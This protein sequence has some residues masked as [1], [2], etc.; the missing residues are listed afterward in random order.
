MRSV[1]AAAA[2]TAAG[3][4]ALCAAGCFAAQQQ[5]GHPAT[6]P[7]AELELEQQ[8]EPEE[9]PERW[10]QELQS[11]DFSFGE[12]DR[13]VTLQLYVV[14]PAAILA[15]ANRA[16]KVSAVNDIDTTGLAAWGL[17]DTL[18]AFVA[19]RR[20]MVEGKR[21]LELGCG[22]GMCGLLA[23]HWASTVV[24]SDYEPAVLALAR[25]NVEANLASLRAQ[26]TVERLVWSRS[27]AACD[28]CGLFD[29]LLGSE[30]LYHETDIG[31]LLASAEHHMDRGAVFVTV[32]HARVWGITSNLKAAA[33]EQGMAIQFVDVS[34]L[35][36]EEASSLAANEA[37]N[38][39]C[40]LCRELEAEA[41]L[42][43]WLA[44]LRLVEVTDED[45]GQEQDEDSEEDAAGAGMRDLF[46]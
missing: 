46:G 13:R 45:N 1:P 10:A 19:E 16:G 32:Y 36:K 41:T 28:S 20:K 6:L 33:K 40:F 21:V 18:S 26:P 29:V 7:E 11:T 8:P 17:A 23:A 15:D 34:T 24:I 2:V 9:L 12:G 27:P 31:A 35:C 39:C 25:R 43:P 14:R 37:S 30:L 44:G 38:Y 5:P 3:T 22:R 42:A 4:A